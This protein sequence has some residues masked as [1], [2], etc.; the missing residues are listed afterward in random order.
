MLPLT[1]GQPIPWHRRKGWRRCLYAF[2]CLAILVSLPKWAP[3]TLQT[4]RLLYWQRQWMTFEEPAD[5]VVFE[6]HPDFAA[7]LSDPAARNQLP[8]AAYETAAGG[9][10]GE[11]PACLT[12]WSIDEA[13]RIRAPAG[14]HTP[15][16]AILFLHG[17][18]TPNGMRCIVLLELSGYACLIEMPGRRGRD[19][20]IFY[21]V[22]EPGTALR[23]PLRRQVGWYCLRER[24]GGPQPSQKRFRFFAGQPD[25]EDASHF[26][27]QYEHGGH[28]GM[29]DGYLQDDGSV[30]L[31]V[32]DGPAQGW[33]RRRW[34]SN[35]M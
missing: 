15:K 31:A 12:K 25:A 20:G 27:V 30:R 11:L 5:R 34:W 6:E 33:L 1:Y 21:T 19:L 24:P 35:S 14:P 4:A 16:T 23:R 7:R 9:P 3:P 32:R 26:T 28:P 18:T 17:R 29:I 13:Y 10:V 2:V 22:I 8:L